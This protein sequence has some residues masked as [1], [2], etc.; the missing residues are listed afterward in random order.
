MA[1][2]AL[3]ADHVPSSEQQSPGERVSREDYI[4]SL[5]QR[6]GG[7]WESL[8][9]VSLDIDSVSVGLKHQVEQFGDQRAAVENMTNS[10]G[11]ISQAADTARHVSEQA[12]AHARESAGALHAAL[13][14]VG[15]LVESVKRIEQK[16]GGLDNALRRVSKVSQEIATI[17]HQTRLLA[18]NA[19]IEAARAGEAGKGFGVVAGEVKALSQQT[20]DA[21][22]HIEETVRELTQLIRE[23]T[24]ESQSSLCVANRV[25]ES[26]GGMSGVLE[27]MVTQFDV[28]GHHVHDIAEAAQRNL[29]ECSVVNMSLSQAVTD[30]EK[31]AEALG[32]ANS[33]TTELLKFSEG[34]I[35]ELVGQGLE[36]P[37]TPFIRKVQQAATAIGK[38]F[39]DAV[40]SGRIGMA[41]L[42][43][44]SYKPIPGTDPQQVMTR[45]TDFTDRILP[46]IQE[47]ILSSNDRI[48][49]CAAVDRNGYLPTH[50]RKYSQPQ[51]R[52]PVWNAANCRNR[53]IFND[54]VG[55]GAARNTKPFVLRTYRRDMG[56]G[57][58]IMMKDV[59]APIMVNGRHW[60]GFRMGYRM[61]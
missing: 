22:G 54:P 1:M 14:D 39:E 12:T 46:E 6:I 30:V 9:E 56:G 34:L 51:T 41:D 17:A 44:E 8:A 28:V 18:L 53:R 37:D 15:H 38:M 10:N 45:F 55:L 7:L 27:E 5:A 13:G 31:E 24:G 23:L 58:F 3:K 49:F 42:F 21:T 16:L 36:V 57:E 20:S 2:T 60:G 19:T 43:D 40:N 48:M 47:P 4:A 59:S 32:H 11:A 35:E 33:R 50:N 25:Q 29:D 26:T 52:D 61:G